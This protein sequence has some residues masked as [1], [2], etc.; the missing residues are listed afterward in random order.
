MF[1]HNYLLLSSL[2][3]KYSSPPPSIL[4]L[5]MRLFFLSGLWQMWYMPQPIKKHKQHRRFLAAPSATSHCCENRLS[6][7]GPRLQL[8]PGMRS[9]PAARCRPSPN[10]SLM[11]HECKKSLVLW[12][13]FITQKSCLTQTLEFVKLP[14]L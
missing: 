1:G 10:H 14:L 9:C 2:Y 7:I 5:A 8:G 12:G 4:G 3:V 13:L 11:F 6:Q